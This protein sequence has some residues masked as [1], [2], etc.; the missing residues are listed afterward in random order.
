MVNATVRTSGD[1]LSSWQT[2]LVAWWIPQAAVLAVCRA[3]ANS[4]RPLDHRSPLDGDGMH[5][6][7]KTMRPH[8]LPLHGTYYLAMVA[9]CSCWL[10]GIVT[11]DSLDG[12]YWVFSFC[13]KQDHLVGDGTGLGKILV[14]LGN[15]ATSRELFPAEARLL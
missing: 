15:R 11:V 2:N 9:R 6:E 8:P 1:W 13:R 4:S 10:S 14:E 3:G 12:S 5:S 7:C